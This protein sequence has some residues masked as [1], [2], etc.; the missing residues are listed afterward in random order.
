MSK[1]SLPQTD[2]VQEL[3]EFWQTHDSTDFDD[4]MEEVPEPVF[5]RPNPSQLLIKS[6]EPEY[7]CYVCG[8]TRHEKVYVDEVFN[9]DGKHVM[10][11]HIPAQRCQ[12]CGELFFDAKTTERVLSLLHDSP[13]V[14][15]TVTLDV[16][17][18]AVA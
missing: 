5:I 7:P 10:V 8:S 2:S 4:E 11:E 14:A 13:P 3:A 16:F 1:S 9:V 15:R 18:L 6:V 17:D 12:Q